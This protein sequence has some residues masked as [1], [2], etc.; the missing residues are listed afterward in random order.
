M[1]AEPS[2]FVAPGEIDQLAYIIILLLIAGLYG[3]VYL[4]AAFD[5]WAEH[6]SIDTPLARTIPTLLA[7]AL[8]Y[9]LFPLNHFNIL[10]P[11]SVIL[12]AVLAD[13]TRHRGH[14]ASETPS[15]AKEASVHE[16]ESAAENAEGNQG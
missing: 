14:Q 7:I 11:V 9:E 13:W 8:L 16:V 1:H 2:W 4:Y 15:E 6:E 10:L 12:L 3:T 5:R